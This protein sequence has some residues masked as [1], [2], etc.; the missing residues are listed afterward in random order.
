MDN[1][2]KTVGENHLFQKI[3]I[4]I[5]ITGSF[6]VSI[7]ALSYSFF[8][9]MPDFLCKLKNSTSNSYQNC[10]YYLVQFHLLMIL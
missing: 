5:L 7:L 1:I 2:F 8:T 6:L 9:K 4:Y 3:L 10:D